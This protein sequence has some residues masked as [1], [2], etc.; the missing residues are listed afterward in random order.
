MSTRAIAPI[1]VAA[2]TFVTLVLL[3]TLLGPVSV[4]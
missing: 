2:T 3:G 4:K 1:L